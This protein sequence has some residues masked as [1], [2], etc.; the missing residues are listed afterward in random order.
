MPETVLIDAAGRRRANVTLPGYL[1]AR[2][3]H[4]I[5]RG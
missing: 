2:A 5:T 3:P 1:T 4:I